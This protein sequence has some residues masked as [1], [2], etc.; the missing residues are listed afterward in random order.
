MT[1]REDWA[2]SACNPLSLSIKALAQW[3]S[4]VGVGLWTGICPPCQ[5][6]VS[7]IKHFPS[8]QPGPYW[9][10]S[11]EQLDPTFSCISTVQI[12]EVTV[13]LSGSVQAP[14]LIFILSLRLTDLPSTGSVFIREDL[15]REDQSFFIERSHWLAPSWDKEL[16]VCNL[17]CWVCS[18]N[19]RRGIQPIPWL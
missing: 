4:G 8:H 15:S 14:C 6:P 17:L 5:R 11:G 18:V 3:L 13:T 12:S 10:L 9:L 7:K 2:V 1:V 19:V 16:W